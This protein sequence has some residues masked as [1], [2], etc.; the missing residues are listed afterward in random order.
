MADDTQAEEVPTGPTIM[1][2]KVFLY[3][4]GSRYEGEYIE[5]DVV[6]EGEAEDAAA[7]GEVA[8]GPRRLRHGHGV[9]ISEGQS[10]EG[11]WVN[12]AMEGYGIFRFLTGAQYEGE[13]Q[14]NR[15]HGK[16]KYRWPDGTEYNGDFFE[17]TMHGYGE[18]KDKQGLM[19][20]GDFVNGQGEGILL[21]L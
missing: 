14:Q 16:G 19:W 4:D 12:D 6:A 3:P 9:F 20:K 1:E 13:M 10:Y 5:Q 2:S 18:F 21:E 8:S 11:D 7:G 17:G 15:F